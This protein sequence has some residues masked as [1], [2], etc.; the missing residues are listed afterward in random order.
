MIL[1]GFVGVI[2]LFVG[3]GKHDI[4]TGDR[5]IFAGIALLVLWMVIWCACPKVREYYERRYA[6]W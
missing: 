6:Q 1:L 5:L 4:V 3:L 2:L